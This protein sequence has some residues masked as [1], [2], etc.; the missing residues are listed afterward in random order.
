MYNTRNRQIQKNLTTDRLY[1]HMVFLPQVQVTY[2][3]VYP[4]RKT[5]NSKHCKVYIQTK[6]T[7][8]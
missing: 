6:V 1:D 4:E 7:Q 5:I 8:Y 3:M 2:T